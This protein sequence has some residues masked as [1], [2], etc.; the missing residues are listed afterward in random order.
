MK[1]ALCIICGAVVGG[2][3]GAIGYRAFA[4]KKE[5]DKMEKEYDSYKK[6][7]EKRR[8]KKESEKGASKESV[9]VEEEERE[10]EP[11]EDSGDEEEEDSKVPYHMFYKE[12]DRDEDEDDE[13]LNDAATY[14]SYK[15]YKKERKKIISITEAEFES[16]PY[17]EVMDV[18]YLNYYTM[19]N[20]LSDDEDEPVEDEQKLIGD[21]LITSDFSESDEDTLYVLNHELD[22]VFVIQ[23]NRT[24]YWD[25]H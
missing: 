12:K 4:M 2:V 9:T 3:I 11:V 25:T 13:I 21:I 5:V 18:T 15:K 24:S 6:E 10:E 17:K 22:T 8:K 23:K 7:Y 16:H 1:H 19:D 20:E 14:E